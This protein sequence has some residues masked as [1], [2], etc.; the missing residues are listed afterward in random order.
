[1]GILRDEWSNDLLNPI[2]VSYCFVLQPQDG[3]PLQLIVKL[4]CLFREEHLS[5]P[6]G[7]FPA[8]LLMGG[9]LVRYRVPVKPYQ[10]FR[11]F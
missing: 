4:G 11:N 3:V 2:R 6:V 10:A 5:V 8:C 7:Q 1:M 9:A